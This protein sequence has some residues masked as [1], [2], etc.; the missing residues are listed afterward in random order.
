MTP[1][2]GVQAPPEIVSTV[3]GR[4][5][6]AIVSPVVG[7]SAAAIPRSPTAPA[8]PLGVARNWLAGSPVVAEIAK[9]PLDVRGEPV[10]VSQGGVVS[11]TDVSPPDPVAAIVS[12]PDPGVIVTFDP[13]VSVLYSRPV[14]P[15]FT[16]RIWDAVPI[17]VRFVPPDVVGT[18]GRSVATRDRKA[19][20]PA[21]PLVGPAKMLFCPVL[22]SVAVSVPLVVTGDPDTVRIDGRE[23]PTDE[24]VPVPPEAAIVSEPDPG[25]IV[26]F[27]P[28]VSVL[29]S[30]LVPPVFTPRIWDAVPIVVR[31]VPPEL[32]GTVGRSAATRDRK[33]GVPAPP[34]VGPA[35]IVFCPVLASVAVR[36]PLLVTGDPDTVRIDGRERPTDETVPVPPEAAIVSEPDPGVIVTFDPAVS[37]LY[38]RLVPPVFT[39]R[40]WDA[41]PIVVRFVPPELVGTVGRSAATR[42]RKAGVPAPPLVGPA[43]IVFCPVLASVAVR[44]PLLVTGDPDTVRIDGRERPTDV[45]VPVP[46]EAAIV[47]EPDPGV[48]VTFDP[49]VSVLYSRPVH[50]Y[51]RPESGT[52]CRSS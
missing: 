43:K 27:D 12:E 47:S 14:P 48:I 23:R 49:A 41:V 52:P 3:M 38:S 35:K 20:V 25:V 33:A 10:T 24:T 42:D 37:V 19:G 31:F 1:R 51:S 29:Y 15:V 45:T 39:P 11:P 46:P 18:V 4:A 2:F 32:V 5:H 13:A 22:A 17:V 6:W 44:V 26:T 30:R 7:K 21:P 16:P 34:L 9:V 8:D 40:I 36:V 50:R 28:A